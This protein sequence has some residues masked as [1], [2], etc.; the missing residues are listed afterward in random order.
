MS[1]APGS[2][3]LNTGR[4][5]ACMAQPGANTP[6]ILT[7]N[8]GLIGLYVV[9]RGGRTAWTYMRHKRQCLV[10]NPLAGDY[11]RKET[12]PRLQPDSSDRAKSDT[13]GVVAWGDVLP[14]N[15]GR[16]VRRGR[17]PWLGSNENAPI[18]ASSAMPGC[19]AT[20]GARIQNGSSRQG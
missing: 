10:D 6:R 7:Q 11:N 4:T 18:A 16:E 12:E 20:A 8:A 1:V 3:P 14:K 13:V 15:R 19:L 9:P 5:G 17:S 2:M